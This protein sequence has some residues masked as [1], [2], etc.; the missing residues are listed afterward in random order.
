MA[1]MGYLECVCKRALGAALATVAAIAVLA[2]GVATPAQAGLQQEYAV[3]TDCPVNDPSVQLCIVST[4]TS[5]EFVIGSKTVPIN[6]TVTLQGG[7]AGSHLVPAADGNTLSKTPLQLPGGLV[8]LE[9]LPPL[10]EVTATAELAGTV[11]IDLTNFGQQT[12]TAVSMPI[13]VK[14]DNP[15]LGNAC[16]IGSDPEPIVLNLTSGT[17][18]PPPPNQPISGSTGTFSATGH[19]KILSF[20]G[21]S[22]VDNAFAA[23]GVN[24]CGGL[25]ALV[26]DPAVDLDAGLPSAAGKNT[27]I[28]TG[29]T[30]VAEK[31]VVVQEAALPELGRCVKVPGEGAGREKVFH[32]RFTTSECVEETVA[33][34]GKFEWI[35]GPGPNRK[36]SGSGG[37]AKLETPSKTRVICSGLASSGE[38]TGTKTATAT[39]HFTGCELAG[40][41]PCQ[42]AGAATGEV[43]TGALAAE[44]GLIHSEFKEGVASTSAGLDLKRQPSL[45]NAE[46]GAGKVSLSV[47]GSVIG[48]ITPVDK[49]TSAFTLK[50]SQSAGKQVPEQFE[51]GVKDTLTVHLGS[52]TEAAG[53]ASSSKLANEEKLAVKAEI[54]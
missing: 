31:R 10:T 21:N 19:G 8:G 4:V 18:T 46:C 40:S 51:G 33:K 7:I 29:S 3:F 9:V 47:T 2:F 35:P 25:L 26:V 27:A 17:T 12:G 48:Q 36:F 6:R 34:L 44:L 39:L 13:K 16:F 42:S 52:G 54:E 22:L 24:G 20:V 38:Y 30:E 14:L 45:L 28:M 50:F 41:G 43:V 53:L 15:S 37:T 32:G 11:G 5:G 1:V 49:M 23:P